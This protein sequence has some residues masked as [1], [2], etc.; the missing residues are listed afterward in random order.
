MSTVLGAL[1]GTMSGFWPGVLCRLGV[2]SPASQLELEGLF[3]DLQPA[4]LST[5]HPEA[6]LSP[7][8]GC[9]SSSS[10][11]RFLLQLHSFLLH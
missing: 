4:E 3:L 10:E 5:A 9:R 11:P 1:L 8:L 2:P 6:Q 7:V